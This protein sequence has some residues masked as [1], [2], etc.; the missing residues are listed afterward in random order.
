MR[1]R[2]FDIVRPVIQQNRKLYAREGVDFDVSQEQFD[3][4][5]DADLLIV[6]DVLQHWSNAAIESFLP[7]LKR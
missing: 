3:E 7:T 4:R 5:P 2:G 6:K 1:Y